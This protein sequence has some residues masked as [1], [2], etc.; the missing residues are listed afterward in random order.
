MKRSVCRLACA[1]SLSRLTDQGSRFRQRSFALSHSPTI[2]QT[3][4]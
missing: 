1:L 2:A 3:K 4:A